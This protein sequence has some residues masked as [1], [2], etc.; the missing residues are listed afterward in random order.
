MSKKKYQTGAKAVLRRKEAI[1][2]ITLQL[3]RGYKPYKLSHKNRGKYSKL[4]EKDF[5]YQKNADGSIAYDKDNKPVILGVSLSVK[6][7]IRLER[8]LDVLY[9]R[10]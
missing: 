6:D 1:E 9:S 3:R 8:E 5:I 7:I 10:I 2:Q 4:S